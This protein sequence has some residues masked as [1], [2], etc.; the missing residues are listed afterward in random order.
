[1]RK[2]V[3]EIFEK[4]TYD[5]SFYDFEKIVI[6]EKN[7]LYLLLERINAINNKNNK[8]S[9]INN[10]TNELNPIYNEINK[11][12]DKYEVTNICNIQLGRLLKYKNNISEIPIQLYQGYSYSFAIN[13]KKK[14]DGNNNKNKKEK[15]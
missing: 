5:Y 13:Y 4:E 3:K 9:K 2:G 1:M 15:V 8:N 11:E 7:K 12:L 10:P 14:P 6:K